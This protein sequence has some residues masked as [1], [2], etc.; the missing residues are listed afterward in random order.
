MSVKYHNNVLPVWGKKIKFFMNWNPVDVIPIRMDDW[1]HVWWEWFEVYFDGAGDTISSF[2][3]SFTPDTGV[4][5]YTILWSFWSMPADVTIPDA[6]T[7]DRWLVNTIAQ[8]FAWDK[9][10]NNNVTVKNKLTVEWNTQLGNYV[11]DYTSVTWDLIVQ[12][13]LRTANT[14]HLPTSA[15]N[16]TT[17]LVAS[18]TVD[19][20]SYI[21]IDQTNIWA[22]YTIPSPTSPIRGIHLWIS[23]NGT[24][25]FII[26]WHIVNPSSTIHFIFDGVNWSETEVSRHDSFL[27]VDWS[28]AG[29]IPNTIDT[30]IVNNWATDIILTMPEHV[31]GKV[32]SLVRGPGST[33]SV[34]INSWSWQIGSWTNT[35]WAT[36]SLSASGASWQNIMFISDGTNWLRK[37]NG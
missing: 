23:N 34:Q 21:Q 36:T 16:S 13:R 15:A 32:V 20:Y 27:V 12:N 31:A 11:S 4:L 35:L 33:W 24:A 18:S 30:A 19:I 14:L 17:N 7:T 8:T 26:H 3:W 9:T 1:P 25:A 10:F 37:N 5:N 28:G 22:T 6:T 29:V 2:S